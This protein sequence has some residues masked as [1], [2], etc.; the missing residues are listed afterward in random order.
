VQETSSSFN[1]IAFPFIG[2]SVVLHSEKNI[3]IKKI[4]I[5]GI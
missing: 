2:G 4:A 1:V 3:K 5:I